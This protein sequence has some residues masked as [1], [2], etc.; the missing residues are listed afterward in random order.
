[1]CP[2]LCQEEKMALPVQKRSQ[3]LKDLQLFCEYLCD[4]RN[5]IEITMDD[6]TNPQVSRSNF[7]P[8]S[9]VYTISGYSNTIILLLH[10][11]KLLYLIMRNWFT[12]RANSINILVLCGALL[13]GLCPTINAGV[14]TCVYICMFVYMCMYLCV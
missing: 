6:L 13:S 4:G 14:C 8:E 2:R 9:G 1:M 5:A 3:I 10:K 11:M 7:T 12:A